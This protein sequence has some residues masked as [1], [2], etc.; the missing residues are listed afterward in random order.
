[1]PALSEEEIVG[2]VQPWAERHMPEAWTKTQEARPAARPK[3]LARLITRMY[4]RERGK[5]VLSLLQ[6][7]DLR[8]AV[9]SK[10]GRLFSLGG[11]HTDGEIDMDFALLALLYETSAD[12]DAVLATHQAFDAVIDHSTPQALKPYKP[13]PKPAPEPPPP[14]PKADPSIVLELLPPSFRSRDG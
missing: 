11:R 4:Q 6:E 10:S 13:V 8:L 7:S 3:F 12:V 14:T 5:V 1:M 2:L 9:R